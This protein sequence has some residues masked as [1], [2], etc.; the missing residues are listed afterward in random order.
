M[1]EIRPSGSEGGGS[2]STAP[3]Y[4]YNVS[5][6]A[7]RGGVCGG[8]DAEAAMAAGAEGPHIWPIAIV[9]QHAFAS[10]KR[11]RRVFPGKSVAYA[12]G[13]LQNFCEGP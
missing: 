10:R 2:E 3:P 4:P 8:E 1:R 11:K 7:G 13:S 9:L 12:S 6:R 5:M